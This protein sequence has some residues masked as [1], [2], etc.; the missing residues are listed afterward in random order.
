MLVEQKC[1][2]QI[3]KPPDGDGVRRE[4]VGLLR[5]KVLRP[6]VLAHRKAGDIR[7]Y[8]RKRICRWAA[9]IHVAEIESI[10]ARKIM[11]HA[12]AVLIIIFYQGLRRDESIF[13]LVR[14]REKGQDVGRNRIDGGYLVV[15]D[16]SRRPRGEVE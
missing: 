6:V 1:I 3:G 16:R 8:R 14:Q 7:S 11:V 15:R 12:D 2:A 4:D 13:A 9:A 10:G 5:D